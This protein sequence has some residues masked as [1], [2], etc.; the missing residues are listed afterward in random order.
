MLAWLD[1][2]YDASVVL[3]DSVSSVAA[4]ATQRPWTKLDVFNVWLRIALSREY[5]TS[6]KFE[7]NGGANDDMSSESSSNMT[8]STIKSRMRK[9]R[10]GSI[11]MPFRA[12]TP[13]TLFI[14][15]IIHSASFKHH[16]LNQLLHTM[17]RPVALM[18]ENFVYPRPLAM[19]APV[20]ASTPFE[21]GN[22]PHFAEE[23]LSGN[24]F[25]RRSRRFLGG[26]VR[27]L[28]R[29]NANHGGNVTS[30]SANDP[31]ISEVGGGRI[32]SMRIDSV[33][34]PA[35]Q[36]PSLT[37]DQLA[38]PLL[39]PVE[40]QRIEVRKRLL[41]LMTLFCQRFED[42]ATVQNF[43]RPLTKIIFTIRDLIIVTRPE[44]I[45]VP[46]QPDMLGDAR[47]MEEDRE[48]M[49]KN[50]M[51][52]EFGTFFTS[53][54][55]LLFLRLICR[56]IISPE[57]YGV[58][59]KLNLSDDR[60]TSIGAEETI[61]DPRVVRSR[62]SFAAMVI[63]SHVIRKEPKSS[64][65]METGSDGS[66]QHGNTGVSRPSRRHR[67]EYN[68]DSHGGSSSFINGVFSAAD[69]LASK[70]SR[71]AVRVFLSL[72]VVKGLTDTSPV[73]MFCRQRSA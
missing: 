10:M 36:R 31:P 45:V 35:V 48:I 44:H 29:L 33:D 12:D 30:S 1:N 13:E 55:A 50:R 28:L 42:T 46:R 71:P 60:S 65:A 20:I 62:Q 18:P 69:E 3:D 24:T 51:R 67:G 16:V 64:E 22:Q 54:S 70:S 61:E 5:L 66:Q 40:L 9:A 27:N 7:E 32:S 17:L 19:N 15:S 8:H 59:E 53:C 2:D 68:N 52:F 11:I 34:S 39:T 4:G 56:A 58:L 37:D 25:S 73:C 57:E 43:P 14:S 49:Y 72:T 26:V 47:M 23:K 21:V 63:L 41:D 6:C 38:P